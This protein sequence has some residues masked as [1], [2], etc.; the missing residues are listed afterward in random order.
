MMT[1]LRT[2]DQTISVTFKR[3]IQTDGELESVNISQHGYGELRLTVEQARSL[4]RTLM[5]KF[6]D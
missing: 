5:T 6:G 4:G 1:E 3:G 2:S